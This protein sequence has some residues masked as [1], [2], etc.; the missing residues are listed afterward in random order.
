MALG[1]YALEVGCAFLHD[2]MMEEAIGEH[3][4]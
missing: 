2:G 1:L 3:K 4:V